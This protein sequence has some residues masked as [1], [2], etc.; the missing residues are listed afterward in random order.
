MNWRNEDS[1]NPGSPSHWSGLLNLA[2]RDAHGLSALMWACRLDQLEHVNL[3]LEAESTCILRKREAEGREE[4]WSENEGSCDEKKGLGCFR[5]KC[6]DES[7]V[8][9]CIHRSGPMLCLTVMY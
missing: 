2:A 8:H 6:Q 5:I 7:W 4:A 3:L 9:C 1:E